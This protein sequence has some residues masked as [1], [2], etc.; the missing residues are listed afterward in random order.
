MPRRKNLEE[1]LVEACEASMEATG[2]RCAA[3]SL[4]VVVD[5][6]IGDPESAEVE[7]DPSAIY[8]TPYVLVDG[9]RVRYARTYYLGTRFVNGV[10]AAEGWEQEMGGDGIPEFLIDRCRSYLGKTVL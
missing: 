1:E 7:D 3:R 6:A 8:A 10:I 2:E 4:D 5:V 9:E